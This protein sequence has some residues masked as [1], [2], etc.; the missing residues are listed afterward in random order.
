MAATLDSDSDGLSDELEVRWYTDPHNTDSDGDGVNDFDEIYLGFTPWSAE[1]VKLSNL[2]SDNDGAPDSWE[3]RL[4]LD[5]RNP[6][7]D[8]DGYQDSWEINNG[9]NPATSTNEKIEKKIIVNLNQQRL[10]Y[11]FNN[12]ELGNFLISSGLPRTPTPRGTFA[13][14]KKRPL[15]WYLGEN[16]SYPGTQWNLLFKQGALGGYYVHGAYWHNKFGRPMSHGCVNVNYSDMERLYNFA[17]EDMPVI[18]E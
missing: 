17:Q 11:Y 1:A 5:L 3:M 8:G 16:Y 14:L 10:R 18:I 9:F 13:V 6:D 2:D 4:N 7:S 12:V 15:V